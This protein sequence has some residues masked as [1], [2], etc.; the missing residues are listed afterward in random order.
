MSDL[1]FGI[2]L[3]FL[4][5]GGCYVCNTCGSDNSSAPTETLTPREQKIKDQF[6]AWDGSHRNMEKWVK[7]HMNDPGSYEHVETRYNDDGVNLTVSLK[8]RGRNAFG[9][10]VTQT[11]AATVDVDGNFVE[12][13]VIL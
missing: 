12:G 8:F 13:P 6:S 1:A 2:I 4:L 5:F 3:L 10:V 11:A 9:G 7:A